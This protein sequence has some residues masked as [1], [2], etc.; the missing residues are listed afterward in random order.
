VTDLGQEMSAFWQKTWR[1]PFSNSSVVDHEPEPV[2]AITT[3]SAADAL[4]SLFGDAELSDVRLQGSDGGTVVAVKAILAARSPVFRARFFGPTALAASTIVKG[5]DVVIFKEWDCRVLHLV[6]EFCYTDNL[7]IMQAK[8]NDDIARLMANLRSASKA[9]KLRS[10]LDKVN[11][12]SWRQVS[13]FP[14]LA[15]ALIDEG[16]KRDDIDEIALQTVQ[17]K[18]RAAL[19][20]E[21]NAVGSGVICLTKPALLFVLRTLEDTTSPLLLF[22]SIQRWVEFSTEDSIG[23]TNHMRE[24]SSREAF[25]RKCAMRFIKLS[26][27]SPGHL[28]Q[29]MKNSGLFKSDDSLG[30]SL[31][32]NNMLLDAGLQFSQ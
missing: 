7:S 3:G 10:L 28:E 22:H 6:V 30:S 9:F 27:I 29:V 18:A 14:S 2:P 5:K 17:L 11:Q 31:T 16:M 25:A 8:P 23:D 1:R 21:S 24:K 19:L 26:R 32:P 20:P 12:W 4:C 15:C 13:R